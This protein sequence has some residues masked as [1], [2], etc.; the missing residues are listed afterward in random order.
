LYDSNKMSR[1][2]GNV[3]AAVSVPP[4]LTVK[5]SGTGTYTSPTNCS[6]MIVE[7]IGGGSSGAN[8]GFPGGGGTASS[9][10]MLKVPAGTYAY[11]VGVGGAG[12][13]SGSGN[14]G[15]RSLFGTAICGGAAGAVG[16]ASGDYGVDTLA[17]TVLLRIRGGRGGTRGFDNNISSVGGQSFLGNAAGWQFYPNTTLT[18]D[19][20]PARGYGAGGAGM[21]TAYTGN[22]GDGGPGIIVIT[23]YY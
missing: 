1:S 5:T 21:S 11:E 10:M 20:A 12:V 3:T 15:T 6:Y 23:E 16:G 7:M 13:A 22:S 17:Y 9:Y 14:S 2:I 8:G 4:T 19:F 18:S